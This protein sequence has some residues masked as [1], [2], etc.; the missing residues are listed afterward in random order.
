MATPTQTEIDAYIAH[1]Q[2]VQAGYYRVNGRL[3][4]VVVETNS[5]GG[6][7][8]VSV[9]NQT[10]AE[11]LISS[12]DVHFH[13]NYSGGSSHTVRP[14]SLA[15]FAVKDKMEWTRRHGH[16]YH[17]TEA[18]RDVYVQ[19]WAANE[20]PAYAWRTQPARIWHHYKTRQHR[21]WER[22]HLQYAPTTYTSQMYLHRNDPVPTFKRVVLGSFRTPPGVSYLHGYSV[23]E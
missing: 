3:M 20:D 14:T 16:V 12:L 9:L 8:M 4:R 7:W 19:V 10:D 6:Q 13:G 1:V 5:I 22:R 17:H 2:A 21:K 18:H 11:A 15:D 23:Y